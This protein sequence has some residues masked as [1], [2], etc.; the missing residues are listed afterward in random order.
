W[1]PCRSACVPKQIAKGF[2]R[3]RTSALAGNKR[4]ITA[5]SRFQSFCQHRGDRECHVD[6][7]AALFGFDRGNAIAD[8]LPPE[9]NGIAASQ[10]GVKQTLKP[11]PL[12]C[13]DWPSQLV[14]GYVLLGPRQKPVALRPRWISHVRSRIGF[15]QLCPGR[16]SEK[17][18]HR[19]E[20]I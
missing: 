16:P 20:K 14:S 15:D 1:Y 9:T 13:S 4:Q 12:P 5:R 8:M 2:L 3:E 6:G 11:H 19:I 7:E 18:A 17:P 10:P